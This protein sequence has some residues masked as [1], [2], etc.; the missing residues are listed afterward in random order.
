MSGASLPTC[1]ES[2]VGMS[3]RPPSQSPFNEQ[4][5]AAASGSRRPAE[6]CSIEY[7]KN[8]PDLPEKFAEIG[9]E[10]RFL[11]A[12]QKMEFSDP[13]D[14][15]K[16]LIPPALEGR[17]VL[18]QARTG[19]G[20]TAAFGLPILQRIDPNGRLQ[21]ICL[22]PT[23]ELAVQVVAE[24]R[25]LASETNLHI[26]PVYGG[27]RVAT[28]I[29]LL[30]RKT[31]MV[32]GTPGRVMD[33]LNRGVLNFDHV[34]M[35]VL[36][37]VDRMLD[38]GFRDDIRRILGCVRGKQQTIF[39]SATID[40]EIR[41]LSLKY[42]SDPAEINV[43][44]DLIT[45]DE[46]EQFFCT[47][48]R[49]DKY[50]L[51]RTLLKEEDPKLA[52]I[53]CN[54]KA[55]ARKIAQRLHAD[56]IDAKEIHGDLVQQKREKVMERF[57][58][59]QI[60]LLVATD[61]AARGIDISAITHIIN[62]DVPID[63]QVYV[64]RVGRTARMG[65]QGRAITFVT[66]EEGKQITDIEILINKLLIEIKYDGFVAR[67]PREEEAPPQRHIASRNETTVSSNSGAAPAAAPLRK[68]LGSK[69][70]T[71]RRRR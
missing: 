5:R 64:H 44:R 20:K 14:I 1:W 52:I 16:A 23:R 63:T 18:G 48:E 51:L 41:R 15:Q 32:V 62:Y 66:R 26:V 67:A 56:G 4:E 55:G 43:S 17:D 49:Y 6:R 12:L 33:L 38:I 19:T 54:T 57:R 47:V 25:R 58:R 8:H 71:R 31:H 27:Q 10:T 29:H 9:I 53:F 50:R 2:F 22:S 35:C 30:G 36:D 28:Q 39:V 61:L 42:M 37:E 13:S 11:R 59:H 40:E 68:T 69:F 60:R 3:R 7:M 46:I 24:L 65:A 70:R 21:A 34:T 45:V